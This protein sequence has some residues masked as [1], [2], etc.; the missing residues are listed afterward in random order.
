MAISENSDNANQAA[1]SAENTAGGDGVFGKGLRG[2]VGVTDVPGGTGVFGTSEQGIGVWGQSD[3]N[4]AVV[5]VSYSGKVGVRGDSITEG[6][7]GVAGN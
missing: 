1:V 5:G 4:D 3:A 6:G 7:V 2:V